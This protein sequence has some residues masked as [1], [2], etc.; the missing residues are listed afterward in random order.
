MVVSLSIGYKGVFRVQ[1]SRRMSLW[2]S[3]PVQRLIGERSAE[4]VARQ[5]E[6]RRRVSGALPD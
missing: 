6:R 1:K 3:S 2:L 4:Q 5:K